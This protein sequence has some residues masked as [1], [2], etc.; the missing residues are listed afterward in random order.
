MEEFGDG[1]DSELLPE[2]PYTSAAMTVLREKEERYMQQKDRSHGPQ[3]Q[4]STEAS[5][6]SRLRRVM[7][8]VRGT[9]S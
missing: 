8:F 9:D 2:Y 7:S 5:N 4:P 6:G 3:P 1:D